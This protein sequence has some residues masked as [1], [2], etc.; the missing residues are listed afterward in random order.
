MSAMISFY[1]WLAK[2]KLLRTP[3]GDLAREATRDKNFPRDAV[4]LEALMEYLRSTPM[5]SAQVLAV[6]RAAYRSYERSLRPAPM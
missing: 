2:Q 3:L 6:A 1:D 5:G 4:S